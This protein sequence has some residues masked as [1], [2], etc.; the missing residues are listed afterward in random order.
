MREIVR[1]EN[2]SHRFK[3]GKYAFRNISIKIYEGEF[4]I[5]T[6]RNGSGKS[7]FLQH[8]NRL[9]IPTSGRIIYDG[10][11]ESL[12]VNEIRHKIGYVFQN[13]DSQIIGLTVNEDVIF[14]LRNKGYSIK[15]ASEKAGKILKKLRMSNYKDYYPYLLSGGEKRKLAVA[16]IAVTEPDIL[17]LDEPFENLDYESAV[18]VLSIIVDMNKNGK[19]VIVVTHDL[20]KTAAHASRFIVFNKGR[21]VLDG[22]PSAVCGKLGEYGVRKINLHDLK[23]MSWLIN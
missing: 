10:T 12:A 23:K 11:K 22:K 16:S 8:L 6:G 19:T 15:E 3:N 21:L 5:L 20:E 2:L 9:F 13:P 4:I 14:G 17:I 7:V 18:D 1:T